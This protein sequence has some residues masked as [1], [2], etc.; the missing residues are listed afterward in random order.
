[1]VFEKGNNGTLKLGDKDW[2]GDFAPVYRW[3]ELTAIVNNVHDN[4]RRSEPGHKR[5]LRSSK[6]ATKRRRDHGCDLQR[7]QIRNGCT[8]ETIATLQG[9]KHTSTPTG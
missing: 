2:L 3:Q 4:D 6:L 9:L 1:M 8:P 7:A 5:K